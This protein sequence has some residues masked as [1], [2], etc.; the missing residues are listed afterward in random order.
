[1]ISLQKQSYN[2]ILRLVLVA[3]LIM[4]LCAGL[5]AQNKGEKI[6]GISFLGPHKPIL[7]LSMVQAIDSVNADWIAIIPEATLDRGTLKLLP[8]SKNPNWG[9]TQEGAIEIIKLSKQSSKKI[10]LKPQIILGPND[11]PNEILNEL[12]S[13]VNLAYQKITDKT[14]GAEWRGDFEAVSESDWKIFES[15]YTQYILSYAQIAELNEVEMFCIGTELRESAIQRPQFWI[16]LIQKVREVYNGILIYSA[17]WDEYEDI[18]F[19]K[20]L[21][22]IGTNAYYPISN[23]KTPSVEEAFENWRLIRKDLYKI[24]KKYNR[25]IIITEYGYRS[26]SYTGSK[27][28]I[29]DSQSKSSEANN[30]AQ[31]NLYDAFYKAFWNEYWIA[32]GFSWNWLYRKQ[33]KGNTDFSVQGK[34]AMKIIAEIYKQ[35]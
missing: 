23:A 19:W 35:D 14:Y 24:S 3:T 15:S 16:K 5:V 32:G 20:H 8:D 34:P 33:H 28:W 18:T 12:A 31:V 2:H 9:E 27:P 26:T 17:N 10:L 29:H 1:M 21:D 4:L 22:Y 7:Q 30:E 13:Y 6:K 11:N 25:K